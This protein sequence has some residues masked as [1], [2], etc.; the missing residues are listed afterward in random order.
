MRSWRYL[1]WLGL[2]LIGVWHMIPETAG[3]HADETVGISRARQLFAERVHDLLSARC[4]GCHGDDPDQVEGGLEMRSLAGITAGGDSGV[5]SLAA[6]DPDAS[7]LFLAVLRDHEEWPAMPPKE[8]ERLS[9]EEIEWLRQWILGGAPWLDLAERTALLQGSAPLSDSSDGDMVQVSTIGALSESWANRSYSRESLWAYQPVRRPKVPAVEATHP[10]DAFLNAVL[11]PGLAPAPPTD[12]LTLIRRA[13]FDLLGLPPDAQQVST[14]LHDPASDEQAFARL[15]DR[16]LA[17]PY[18]GERQ[19]QHWLDVVRY[20]DS[21]GLANDYQRGNAWRYRD[22]VVRAFNQDK[23]YDEFIREQIAGDELR[24]NDP[25][26]LIATG[27]LRMGPWELT[28]MEVAKIARQRFLDDVTNSVGETFL[29][30]SLQCARCH[31]HK[32]DPVPTHDF[33]AIQAVFATTQISE[34]SAPFLATENVSH[35]EEQRYLRQQQIDFQRTLESLDAKSLVAAEQWHKEHQTDPTIWNQAVSEAQQKPSSRIGS[36][37]E[38]ARAALLASGL[39]EER[40]PPRFCG[41]TTTDFGNERVA[42]KGLERLAWELDRYQ[43]YAL[44]VYSG[45]TPSLTAV[46]APL[47]IPQNRAT[48]GEFEQTAILTGGD[49]F[50]PSAPVAP[51]VLS[52]LNLPAQPPLPTS[53]EGRRTGFANWVADPANALTTRA[54]VNRLWLWHFGQPLAGNPNNFGSTGKRPTHPELLDWLACELVDRE[55]S[56]KSMHRLIMTS[57][58]YRRSADHSDPNRLREL[59]PLGK[60]YASFLPRRLSASELRDAMLLASGELN[61][62]VGGIP[63]RPEINR[64]AAMQ[65]RQVMGTFAAAWIPNPRPGQ[66]HRRS[67]YATRLRGL[68]DPLFEVFN[69]PSPAFSCERRESTTVTPQA[70]ALFNSE[71]SHARALALAARARRES[72][73][74]RSTI[75]HLFGWTLA[76]SPSDDER[77]ICLEHWQAMEPIEAN[78]QP[79][80]FTPPLEIRREAVEENT[81]EYFQFS[82]VLH[83]NRDFEPD[84]QPSQT[85]VRTRALA[86]VCLVLLNSNEFIYV[87]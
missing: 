58:A 61:F 64:D 7:P 1:L 65:P 45:V 26:A 87:Y 82:E 78:R 76:R 60:H 11:P 62:E 3:L 4:F 71:T 48:G 49:P 59:D 13:S 83:A 18:Y 9:P 84:L 72:S 32:F 52:A 54:I 34:R 36:V 22:Y 12:R 10:I 53:L 67:L 16:L 29:A 57:E 68:P 79:V 66:R 30:H 6:G 42:R 19:A 47:R 85:D 50:S 5:K 20:A 31:D 39:A 17:S 70:L 86:N 27:F 37:F 75:D 46:Y 33:Y 15:V 51:N 41:F 74:D 73:D 40:F 56:L 63:N 55:W 35:F 28:G 8:S 14:F 25:E 38:R 44:S 43:P 24:P 81:G 80:D 2:C 23:P 77:R 69:E 21:S